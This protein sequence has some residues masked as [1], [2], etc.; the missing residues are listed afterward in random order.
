[1]QP[2]VVCINRDTARSYVQMMSTQRLA[3]NGSHFD[4][5]VVNNSKLKKKRMIE[6]TGKML[7]KTNKRP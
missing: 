1:M 5:K 4:L 3:W 7:N 2:V 6:E